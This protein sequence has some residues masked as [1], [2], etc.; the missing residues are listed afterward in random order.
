MDIDDE[1]EREREGLRRHHR[2][3]VFCIHFGRFF[4]HK[5]VMQSVLWI[6]TISC[7]QAMCIQYPIFQVRRYCPA[8]IN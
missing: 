6:C 4:H 8:V 2:G 5:M 7:E 1:N 3:H